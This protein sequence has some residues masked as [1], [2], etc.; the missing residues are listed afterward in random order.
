MDASPNVLAE[1]VRA[2]R[3]AIDNDLEL[4][5]V[6]LQK[7]DP[8]RMGTV[9]WAKTALP[10]ALGMAALGFWRMRQHRVR[11][12]E[13]PPADGIADLQQGEHHAVPAHAAGWGLAGSAAT[14]LA[15]TAT[16]KAMHKQGGMP[17]LRRAARRNNGFGMTLVLAVATGALLALADVMQERR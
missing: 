6:R 3:V 11:P 17:G 16:R 7:F 15:R 10:V 12:R 4:L 5:R 9:R 2:K 1:T 8:G 13:R 14:M